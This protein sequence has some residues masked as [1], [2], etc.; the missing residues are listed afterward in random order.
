MST[1]CAQSANKILGDF[2][3][4]LRSE[5]CLIEILERRTNRELNVCGHN[6]TMRHYTPR[7]HFSLLFFT[8][9]YS[10]LLE[11]IVKKKK[12]LV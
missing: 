2:P 8:L 10:S 6:N 5:N 11:K 7:Q 1:I 4:C 9:L 3:S 12:A